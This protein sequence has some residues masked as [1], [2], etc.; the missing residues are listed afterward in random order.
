VTEQWPTASAV[1]QLL[2]AEN[3]G[4]SSGPS[5]A[6][7]HRPR[8]L[9]VHAADYSRVE[10]TLSR[11]G[12]AEQALPPGLSRRAFP[13]RSLTLDL[14][15][16]D[17]L[18]RELR[19]T[20]TGPEPRISVNHLMGA[21]KMIP[22]DP[23]KASVGRPVPLPPDAVPAR[24]AGGGNRAVKVGVIDTGFGYPGT[25]LPK[26]ARGRVEL[27]SGDLD[28]DPLDVN[29]PDGRLDHAD[30]HGTFVTSLVLQAAPTATV[31]CRRVLDSG[32]A[33][34]LTLAET[35]LDLREQG[36]TVLNLSFG[37]YA[38][39]DLPPVAMTAAIEIISADRRPGFGRNATALVAAAGNFGRRRPV[40]PAAHDDVLAVA[41]TE[42][43]STSVPS[44]TDRGW[45]VDCHTQGVDLAGYFV[46]FTET[47][48]GG[49]SYPGAARWTGTSFA[50]G[51]VSG[52][53][54]H[55]LSAAADVPARTVATELLQRGEYTPELGYAVPGQHAALG[56]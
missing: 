53:I 15:N 33:D 28:R 47:G 39:D 16:L 49:E 20:N 18:V 45:W 34:E 46:T 43:D 41:A 50:T 19:S 31:V 56:H 25:Q 48:A 23:L 27:R 3:V 5:G 9:L 44:W 7:W 6:H 32:I 17:D 4:L 35:M 8:S 26:W 52:Q 38:L 12:A 10:A 37:G 21:H 51:W 54:A 36:C 40:W 30:G 2:R 13:V 24:S 14:D 1:R 29:P 55:E 42:P 11:W 22:M